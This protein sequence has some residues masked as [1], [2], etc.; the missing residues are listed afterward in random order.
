MG[1]EPTTFGITIRRSNRLSYIYHVFFGSAKVAKEEDFDKKSFQ[2]LTLPA[3]LNATHTGGLNK[4]ATA[5][6]AAGALLL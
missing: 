1:L 3:L 6:L 5:S 2:Y 4:N